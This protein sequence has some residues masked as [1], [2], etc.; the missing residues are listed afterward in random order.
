[1]IPNLITS[2]KV[3]VINLNPY[4][5][6]IS[7]DTYLHTYTGAISIAIYTTIAHV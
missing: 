3:P 4:P 1:M 5:Y 6:T 2:L 7:T